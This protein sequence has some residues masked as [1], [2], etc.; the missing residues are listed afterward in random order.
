MTNLKFT[1]TPK[2][3]VKP[4]RRQRKPLLKPIKQ[5]NRLKSKI[6]RRRRL[7]KK[8]IGW[9]QSLDRRSTIKPIARKRTAM[10]METS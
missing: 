3:I 10:S 4:R 5:T 7:T 8:P 6:R 2:K 9:T 1:N